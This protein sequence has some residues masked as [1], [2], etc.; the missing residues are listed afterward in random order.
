MY[1]WLRRGGSGSK[2]MGE[3]VDCLVN[4]IAFCM[5]WYKNRKAGVYM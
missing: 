5:V 1:R 4:L 2:V 3:E